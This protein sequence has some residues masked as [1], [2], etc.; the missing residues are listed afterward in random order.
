VPLRLLLIAG[1]L[2]VLA[3]FML[4]FRV[5]VQQQEP[6]P[7]RW[8]LFGA[9]VVLGLVPVLLATSRRAGAPGDRRSG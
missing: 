9:G 5:V 6:P 8:G 7:F 2:L 3:S 4:D 1:M